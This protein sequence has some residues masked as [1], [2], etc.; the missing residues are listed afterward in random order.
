MK[1]NRSQEKKKSARRDLKETLFRV[2]SRAQVLE[3][4][5]HWWLVAELNL[6]RRASVWP[7][8]LCY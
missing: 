5:L 1:R 6:E 7:L 8:G 3:G 2:F 4:C